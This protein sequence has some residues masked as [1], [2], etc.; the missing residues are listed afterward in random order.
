M[1]DNRVSLSELI[2]AQRAFD[3]ERTTTFE[4]SGDITAEDIRP[5]IHNALSLAGEA[6]EIANLVKKLDRGDLDFEQVMNELPAELADVMIYVIKI[7][8]QSG[9]DLERAIEQ[10]M[11]VNAQR[12]PRSART[13]HEVSA[14]DPLL[15]EAEA[16]AVDLDDATAAALS[17]IYLVEGLQPPARRDHL[18]AGGLLARRVGKLA[19]IVGSE[20]AREEAWQRLAPTA[21]ALHLSY[22]ELCILA[23]HDS[24]IERVLGSH[25]P[26]SPHAA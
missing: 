6:G 14:G 9:I 12:F 22:G 17:R 26:L 23:R 21:E 11:Q 5:L 19:E 7:A 10:K 2:D 18:V 16:R 4:W 1:S 3:A 13:D 20:V 24:E 8:Y 15:A 25:R